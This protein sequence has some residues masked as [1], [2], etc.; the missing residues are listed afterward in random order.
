MEKLNRVCGIF[1]KALQSLGRVLPKY[2]RR[3]EI[4]DLEDR[5]ILRD[6]VNVRFEFCMD[7]LFR[8]IRAYLAKAMPRGP[9]PI[10]T[11][12][13]SIEAMNYE[14]IDDTEFE[15]LS[16]IVRDRNS[17]VHGYN[18]DLSDEVAERVQE[19]YEFMQ[20]ISTRA[21]EFIE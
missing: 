3:F 16:R 11:Q 21:N 18:E 12:E 1:E 4:E 13:L 9:V 2:D 17:M 15:I 5:R 20:G 7:L 19:Y 14:L 8:V 10:S 6:S